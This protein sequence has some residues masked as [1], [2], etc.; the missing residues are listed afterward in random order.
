[1]TLTVII[2]VYQVE[3]TVGRCLESILAQEYDDM[4]IIAVNDGS[5]DK[6]RDI[7]Q[8][9]ADKD[10][11]IKIIDKENG[12]L[13]SARNAALEIATGEYV[14]FA[15]SDDEVET[16]TY[17][18]LMGIIAK[19]P[20]ID[21]LEYPF[22][23]HLPN[24]TVST[25]PFDNKKYKDM[26]FYFL[27]CKAYNHSYAWNKIYRRSFFNDIRYPEGRVFE[28]VHTL[29]R[30]LDKDPVV[31]TTKEGLY[32]YHSNPK[33]ITRNAGSKELTWLLESNMILLKRMIGDDNKIIEEITNDENLIN[34]FYEY[35][36]HVMNIQ[37][38]VYDKTKNIIIPDLPI[39]V[40]TKN[41][42][43]PKFTKVK[44]NIKEKTGL[45]TLCKIHKM[46]RHPW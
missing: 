3:D 41:L 21:L 19:N 31:M 2:P 7:C 29:P 9:F 34:R 42:D 44:L 43:L 18:K 17:G 4:E 28:D 8:Q 38:D 46:I 22:L 32:K 20:D 10:N 37:L 12:G 33:G 45:K 11:R 30:I 40:E 13:S 23:R 36:A 35:Y 39:T 25:M 5:T 27:E 24:G 1:M 26:L 6:S 15:D 16:G 14:T